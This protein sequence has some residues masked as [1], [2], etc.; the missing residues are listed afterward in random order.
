MEKGHLL[1]ITHSIDISV[2]I[3]SYLIK[4]AMILE[5]N[6]EIVEFKWKQNIEFVSNMKIS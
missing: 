6:E 3:S 2:L 1:V 4:Y 5:K